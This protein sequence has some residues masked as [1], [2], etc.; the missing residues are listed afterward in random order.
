MHARARPARRRR[1]AARRRDRNQ[2]RIGAAV[3]GDSS[4]ALPAHA[5]EHGPGI[6]LPS[7]AV[8][9]RVTRCGCLRRQVEDALP[10]AASA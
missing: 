3:I 9:A 8:D 7:R 5:L 4:V 6:V 2:H 1:S 10:L